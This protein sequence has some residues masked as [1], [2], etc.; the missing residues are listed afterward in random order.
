MLVLASSSFENLQETEI[1][2]GIKTLFS[3]LKAQT[4]AYTTRPSSFGAITD[5]IIGEQVI[6]RTESGPA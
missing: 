5:T 2:S 1:D 4:S 6:S 3:L